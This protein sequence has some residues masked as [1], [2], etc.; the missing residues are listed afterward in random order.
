M[1]Q[2][3]PRG[4]V[5]QRVAFFLSAGD[6]AADFAVFSAVRSAARCDRLRAVAALVLRMFF[7]ADA[8]LGTDDLSR[9]G[10]G[11]RDVAGP[12]PEP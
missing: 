11:A 6:D 5:E 12:S 2:A 4:A 9:G 8:I 3:L 1:D 10:N 7:F